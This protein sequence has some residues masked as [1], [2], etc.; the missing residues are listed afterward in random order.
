MHSSFFTFEQR[1][2]SGIA[3]GGRNGRRFISVGSDS[4][5]VKIPVSAPSRRIE[6]LT[7]GRV[8]ES[9]TPRVDLLDLLPENTEHTAVV[10]LRS[11]E[12]SLAQPWRTLKLPLD[13][14]RRD[15]KVQSRVPIELGCGFEVVER[16][17]RSAF[18]VAL[19]PDTAIVVPLLIGEP[20]AVVWLGRGRPVVVKQSVLKTLRRAT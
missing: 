16:E 11:T 5:G 6:S 19:P 14:R 1:L 2:T 4:T 13:L 17:E 20:R 7:Y 18:L 3:L 12:I 9:P 15:G 10:L 8:I